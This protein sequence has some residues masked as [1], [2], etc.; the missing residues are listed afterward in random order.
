MKTALLSALAIVLF[1]TANAQN[2]QTQTVT[3]NLTNKIDITFVSGDGGS[4]FEFDATSKFEKGLVNI[5]AA[6]LNVKSNRPWKV[7]VAAL[8][9]YFSFN[10]GSGTNQ[11]NKMPA[12][13][14]GV[15]LS[16]S[17][18]FISL[19]S[20]AKDLTSSNVRGSNNF[21]IDYEANPGFEFDAGQ[22]Q[23]DVVYTATQQ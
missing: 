19:S 9:D 11:N 18:S 17:S 6:E 2:S 10:G 22:Y 7:Q 4:V 21:T 14:L 12:S 1:A 15:K 8:E 13:K 16:T 3:L 23:L 20:T 5:S